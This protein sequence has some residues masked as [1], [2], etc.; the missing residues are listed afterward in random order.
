MKSEIIIPENDPGQIQIINQK[1][2][3]VLADN[4]RT[5]I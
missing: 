4:G 2:T 3:M 5:N 1:T